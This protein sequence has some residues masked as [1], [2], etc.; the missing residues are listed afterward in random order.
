MA[1]KVKM[2]EKEVFLSEKHIAKMKSMM[3][4]VDFWMNDKGDREQLC[5][6]AQCVE[7][8][9]KRLISLLEEK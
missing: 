1:Q 8:H 4:I 5:D 2:S 6:A 9:L 3:K 7:I